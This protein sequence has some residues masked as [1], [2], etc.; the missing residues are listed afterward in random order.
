VIG[1]V[2]SHGGGVQVQTELGKGSSFKMYLPAMLAPRSTRPGVS[3]PTWRGEGRILVA[4]HEEGE[5]Y[6]V[7]HMAEELGFTVIEATGGM[8]AVDIFRLRHGDLALVLLD[9]SLPT[10]DGR[11]AFREIHKIDSTIPVVL[12]HPYGVP[13]RGIP[14]EE[15]VAFLGRPYR[16][17]EFRGIL[18]RT[19]A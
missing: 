7:R 14:A 11:V 2:R 6:K 12:G 8:E 5:R 3:S 10:M 9:L 16:L 18:Q 19:L 17:A 1:I 13:E 4:D 15:Q